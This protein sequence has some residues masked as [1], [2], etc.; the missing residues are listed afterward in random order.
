MA[1]PLSLSV[2]RPLFGDVA[3]FVLRLVGVGLA[4]H[5]W[6]KVAALA[7]G[8]GAGLVQA[9][10]G[11]GFPLPH[12]FAWASALA[13]FAGGLMLALGLFTRVAAGFAAFNMAV[14]AFGRHHA[15]E[16]LLATLRLQPVPSETLASWGKP[17]LALVYLAVF[18]ALAALGAGRFSLDH[19]WRGR[20]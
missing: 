19:A 4:L 1:R 18:A 14:A 10:A 17:E 6:P 16:Q 3:L 2:T 20:R 8:A 7:T 12:L 9:V 13:E 11:L 15:L 5:G